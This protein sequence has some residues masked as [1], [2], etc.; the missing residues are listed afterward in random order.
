[1]LE[2]A[3]IGYRRVFNPLLNPAGS[4]SQHVALG[5]VIDGNA[6]RA[7][8]VP[9]MLAGPVAGVLEYARNGLPLKRAALGS[10]ADGHAGQ[11]TR[12]HRDRWGRAAEIFFH[13]D[14]TVEV[15]GPVRCKL[16]A[17]LAADFGGVQKHIEDVAID[18]I[19]TS[20]DQFIDQNEEYRDIWGLARF[21]QSEDLL[22]A[23]LNVIGIAV[24]ECKGCPFENVFGHKRLRKN[25]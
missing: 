14:Q 9:N 2:A 15:F 20:R 5:N 23:A 25:R 3:R 17:K 8:G 13:L 4:L 16:P 1:M 19:V 21:D 10:M 7:L 18:T 12:R 11:F 6:D 24:Q 22:C